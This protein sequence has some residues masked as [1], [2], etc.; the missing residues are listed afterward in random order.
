MIP[1][2]T[3]QF[4]VNL[5]YKGF[6]VSSFFQGVQNI[7]TYASLIAAQPFWFGTAVT[8]EWITE[9]WAP[10]N[11]HARLPIL[12][13]YESS[14]N[15]NYRTSDFWLRDASYLRLKNLQV[16]YTFPKMLTGRFGVSNLKLYVNGQNLVTFSK[17]KDF[18]PEKNINGQNFY[19]YPTVKMY[20]TGIN[21]TF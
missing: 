16:S 13:T 18:D 10:E 19:E 21:L 5:A 17:M 9:A 2:Y 14:V 1:E 8:K 6:G 7:N 12:T 3:Y 4:S 15:E 11:P 20:T